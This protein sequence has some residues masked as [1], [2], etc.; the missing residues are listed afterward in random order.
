MVHIESLVQSKREVCFSCLTLVR[1]VPQEV[2][3]AA[4]VPKL[5]GHMEKTDRGS[6]AKHMPDQTVNK[7]EQCIAREPVDIERT[8]LNAGRAPVRQGTENENE[9]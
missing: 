4:K 5:T 9:N 1:D 8:V 3:I 7:V 6:T 2:Y